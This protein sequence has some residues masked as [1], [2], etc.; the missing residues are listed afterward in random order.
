MYMSFS[1]S[2]KIF[3]LSILF[4]LIFGLFWNVI[5]IIKKNLFKKPSKKL[6]VV[7]DL[8]FCITFSIS[9][10]G[11]FF[12][13]TYSGFRIFVVFGEL[14]GFIFY[15]YIFEKLLTPI[16][17]IIVKSILNI[18]YKI[19]KKLLLRIIKILTAIFKKIFSNIFKKINICRYKVNMVLFKKDNNNKIIKKSDRLNELK[20]NIWKIIIKYLEGLI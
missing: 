9:T 12:N 10:V 5:L 16:I 7:F 2:V 1:P 8:I 17:T 6:I 14:V 18:Y 4:G 19:F 11:F 20:N 15:F 3:L 13:Y